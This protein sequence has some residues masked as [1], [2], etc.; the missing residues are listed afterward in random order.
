MPISPP[1]EAF[2]TQ[3]PM[4]LM[5]LFGRMRSLTDAAGFTGTLPVVWQCSDESQKIKKSLFGYVYDCPVFNLGRVGSLIDPTW[6]FLAVVILVQ[7]RM[8]ELGLCNAF[9]ARLL[10]AAACSIA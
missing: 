8:R 3:P 10:H 6:L 1:A 4:E 7:P 5:A 9:T 2:L